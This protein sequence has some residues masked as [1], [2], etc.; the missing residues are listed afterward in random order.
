MLLRMTRKASLG[1]KES[2]FIFLPVINVLPRALPQNPPSDK[3]D[4]FFKFAKI[5]VGTYPNTLCE[6]SIRG[7]NNRK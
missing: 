7:E 2:I 1:A 5:D 3:S 6:Y 4:F